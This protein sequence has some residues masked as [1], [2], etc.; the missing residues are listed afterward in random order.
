MMLKIDGALGLEP[1]ATTLTPTGIQIQGPWGSFIVLGALG[2]GYQATLAWISDFLGHQTVFDQDCPLA[3]VSGIALIDELEQHLHPRWQREMVERLHTQFPNIQFIATS[4]S[5]ICAG[6]LGDLPRDA[7]SKLFV[8]RNGD[9]AVAAHEESLPI[10]MRY[11]QITTSP[12]IGLD[13]ARDRTTTALIRGVRDA[14][15]LPNGDPARDGE[16][17]S[18][19]SRLRNRST[20]A[21]EDE[22]SRETHRELLTTLR[23]LQATLS[24]AGGDQHD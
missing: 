18:A 10:G 14:F 3:D 5:P 11:D 24:T 2:D 8:L 9:T 13:S 16:I 4:H 23:D 17:D 1:G 12:V 22:R 15:E 21:A 6:G 7:S 20:P 19:M